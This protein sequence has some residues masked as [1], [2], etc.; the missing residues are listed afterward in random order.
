MAYRIARACP[1]AHTR[2][3]PCEN[4]EDATGLPRWRFTMAATTIAGDSRDAAGL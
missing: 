2:P 4:S 1:N 3:S